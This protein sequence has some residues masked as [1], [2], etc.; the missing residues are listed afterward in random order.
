[1]KL[2]RVL[3][4]FAGPAVHGRPGEKISLPNDIAE[5]YK[6]Y[7]I[8]EII[9]DETVPVAFETAVKAKEHF[10]NTKKPEPEIKKP[11]PPKTPI[12]KPTKKK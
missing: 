4:G 12:K 1:M 3:Q 7:G 8:V 11:E 5:S 2:C 10:E 6:Q 9:G